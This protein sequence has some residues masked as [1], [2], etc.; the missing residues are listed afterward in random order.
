MLVTA[1]LHAL[2]TMATAL[3]GVL[4]P[5]A[6]RDFG[7]PAA[8]VGAIQALHY[9][10]T[11]FSGLMAA[12]L[13]ARIG[14]VRVLQVTLLTT[15]LAALSCGVAGWVAVGMTGAP[16][17]PLLLGLWLLATGIVFG[18]GYGL[19]NP[20]SANVLFVATP[21]AMRSLVF[22]I[23][24]TSVPVGFGLA[25]VAFPF[26]VLVMPWQWVC[27]V[28]AVVLVIVA[29][30]INPVRLAVQEVAQGTAQVTGHA[31]RQLLRW[32]DFSSPLRDVL[33]TRTWRRRALMAL[34]YSATQTAATAYTVSFLNLEIGL[35][36]VA[37]G[38]VFAIAQIGGVTGRIGL[39]AIADRWVK[40]RLQLGLVGIAT[41]FFSFSMVAITPQW[42]L[43]AITV[44]CAVFGIVSF[45]WNG[46]FFAE[47]ASIAP[48]GR[49]GHYTGGIQVFISLGAMLGPALYAFIVTLSDSYA[50]GFALMAIPSLLVG[51][52]YLLPDAAAPDSKA[53]A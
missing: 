29:L 3:P 9:F 24:Q 14:A 13:L 47:T 31:R 6:A 41:A 28:M 42:P 18:T 38:S 44:L 17:A 30:A 36:L 2:C 5:V 26:L 16:G 33:A 15:A 20:V 50:L 12:P 4:A 34:S 51:I 19:V 32:S 46:V 39:G 11:I 27:I 10:T 45:A 25:G 48:S 1:G 40:P 53:G 49:I 8:K 35:S 21:P 52:L 7:L 22:S 37:A 23:K 43:A